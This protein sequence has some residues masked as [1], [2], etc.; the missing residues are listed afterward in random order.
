MNNK[1]MFTSRQAR[2]ITFR[3]ALTRISAVSIF[4]TMM[5]SWMLITTA[6]LVSLK[7]YTEK[8]LQV[9][10]YTLSQSVEAA[11]VF[12]DGLATKEI[13]ANLGQQGQF[14]VATVTDVQGR[15]LTEWRATDSLTL[16]HQD[17]IIIRW[18]FPHSVIQPIY[19]RDKLVGYIEISGAD[20][21][22]K[23]FVYFS[24][25]ALTLC[26]ILASVLAIF[27]SRRLH[28]GLVF[29]LQNITAAVHDIRENRNFSRRAPAGKIVEI[30]TLSKDFNS[31]IEEIEHWQSQMLKENDSLLKRS[32][33]DSLTGLANRA[34]FCSTLENLLRDKKG[35][36]QIALLF[37][38]CNHFKPVNDTYG[39]AAGDD[40]LVTI[41]NRL[42]QCV[43][44]ASLPARLGGDEFALFICS[45]TQD[46][47]L[48][49]AT[50]RKIKNKMS[51]PIC[52]PDGITIKM[53][54]SIGVAIADKQSTL[55]SLMEE[56]DK[57][58][59]LEKQNHHNQ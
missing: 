30:D 11:V 34:A 21:T 23:Q 28:K 56:A 45:T 7:Q 15:K 48:I 27:I 10:A 24:L 31:L 22:I 29:D 33:R 39:H 6:S 42:L 1:G 46:R 58:M 41:A 59:Y 19:H 17:K 16:D 54:L 43:G 51:E 55:K 40:V 50:I 9:L 37:I 18:L 12:Q 2:K 35:N 52:L 5:V 8:S 38:D 44:K 49:D 25:I 20:A 4:I 57:N 14:S 32:R 36:A 53:T 3:S 26:I 13:L 47:D